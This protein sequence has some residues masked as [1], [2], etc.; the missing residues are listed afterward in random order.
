MQLP[1]TALSA[2]ALSLG[3][4]ACT[5]KPASSAAKP[6][7]AQAPQT[8]AELADRTIAKVQRI[9]QQTDERL[10]RI[11]PIRDTL[12]L[13]AGQQ[14]PRTLALWMDEG[15]AVKLQ[16]GEPGP[17]DGSSSTFYFA[18]PDLFYA[19]QP[20]AHFVFIGGKLQY[21]CDESWQVNQVDAATL[22]QREGF[23]YE[24]ANQYLGWF[25][26]TGE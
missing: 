6:P 8:E 9:I 23:L 26:G 5:P 10:N 19:A 16:V 20:Y 11:E 13:E 24:E 18:G 3:L 22:D 15:K 2:F 21:W 1:R 7:I 14:A 17:G 12:P 4:Y 25:F